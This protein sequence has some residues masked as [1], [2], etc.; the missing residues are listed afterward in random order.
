MLRIVH[1]IAGL[2]AILTIATFWIATAFSEVFAAEGT[3]VAVKTAIPWGVLL[4][5]PALA[6]AGGSGFVLSRGQRTGLVG[7]KLRRMPIIAANGV[8]V[9]IPS[10]LFLASKANAREFDSTFYAVQG[11]EL[12]AGAVNLALLGMSMRDG[13]KLTAWRRRSFLRPASTYST[14]LVSRE[15]VANGTVAVHL[16][17]PPGFAFTAGQA[18]YVTLRDGT[19]SDVKGHVR[20]FSIASAPSDPDIVIA[21]RVTDSSFKHAL[22][23]LPLNS[24]VEIEGPYGNLTL[25]DNTTRPV[26][27]LAG[28]IGITPFRSMIREAS[29][30]GLARDA[31]LFYSN[32]TPGDAAFVQELRDVQERYTRFHVVATMTGAEGDC[33]GWSGERGVIT[34]EMLAKHVGDVTTPV[35]YVAGPPALVRAMTTLLDELRVDRAQVHA[36]GF[37]GY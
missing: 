25:H 10:A 4:L 24:P 20:T 23:N 18:V 21:T 27:F 3:V 34:R 5:V 36:E 1:P 30:R 8:L 32:R 31:F 37:A 19:A 6:A 13:M 12:I 15:A 9:L 17:K 16:A 33:L 2:V 7:A 11:L 26:V 29:A 14:R 22:A 28:G 35:Y